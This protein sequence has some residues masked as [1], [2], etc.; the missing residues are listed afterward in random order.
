MTTRARL[1]LVDDELAVL[2][3][4][5][6]GLR[7]I[8]YLVTTAHN[9]EGALAC[10]ILNTFDLAIV[11]V[12]LPGISGIELAAYLRDHWGI[13]VMFLSAIDEQVT[14]NMAIQEGGLV[15]LV[16]PV[17]I[18]QLHPAIETA[19]ARARDLKKMIDRTTQLEKALTGNR[20]TS[21]AIGILMAKLNLTQA[22][23]FEQLRQQARSQRQKL[24]LVA[25]A[26]VNSLQPP[27]PKK[28]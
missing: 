19:L 28:A 16:K 14:V 21:V 2:E 7:Q 17:A 9:V 27:S 6:D 3:A 25:E 23:A 20:V 26:V 13:P 22:E 8:G 15:Y 4:T 24:E 10:A 12:R 11:D 18:D 1:L 5:A